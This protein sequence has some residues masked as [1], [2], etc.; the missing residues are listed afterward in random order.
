METKHLKVAVYDSHQEA[1]KAIKKLEESKFPM[2]K[3]SLLGKTSIEEK[4]HPENK[5]VNTSIMV[6]VGTGVLAGVLT[7]LGVFAIPGFGFLYGAGAIVGAIGGLDIGILAGGSA[8][9]LASIGV[10]DDEIET[11]EEQLRK[12][13]F[14]I[15]LH[16]SL[17][18]LEQAKDILGIKYHNP[19]HH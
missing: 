17:E 6:G 5:G 16:G 15:I 7:G 2:K 8:A 4:E 14:V 1:A 10:S 3:L 19:S 13:K 9:L 11:Y 12:G 18:E